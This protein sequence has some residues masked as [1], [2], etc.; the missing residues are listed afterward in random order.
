MSVDV[1]RWLEIF[2]DA[3]IGSFEKLQQVFFNRWVEKKDIRFLF[4]ALTSI[5]RKENES[6][7]NFNN[8]FDKILQYIPATQAPTTQT[9]LTYYLNTFQGMFSFLLNQ[10]Q[11]TTLEDAKENTK[12]LDTNYEMSCKL[13]IMATLRARIESKAK[14]SS[15]IEYSSNEFTTLSEHMKQLHLVVT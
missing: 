1:A 9:K 13:D 5:K 6:I 8:R 2:L 7:D 12:N 14:A 3:S 4:N 10:T 11:A 15:S